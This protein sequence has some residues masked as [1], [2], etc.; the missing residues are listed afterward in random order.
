MTDQ[1]TTQSSFSGGTKVFIA[2]AVVAVVAVGLY[3][4]WPTSSDQPPTPR[5]VTNPGA[6]ARQP[7]TTPTTTTTPATPVTPAT[8]VPA[9]PQQKPS[10]N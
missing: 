3:Y 6:P 5:L 7:Q 9:Q 1:N 10:S 4:I 8:T 2:L